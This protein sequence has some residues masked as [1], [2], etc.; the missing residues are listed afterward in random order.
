MPPLAVE[1]ENQIKRSENKNK[2]NAAK[3][4]EKF[5]GNQKLKEN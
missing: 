4:P 5:I 3:E 1:S 2:D